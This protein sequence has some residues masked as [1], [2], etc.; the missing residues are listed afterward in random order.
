MP[1]LWGRSSDGR[2]FGSHSKGQGFDSP[3]LHQVIYH[4][5]IKIILSIDGFC[6]ARK[7]FVYGAFGLFC[8]PLQVLCRPFSEG[9]WIA[10]AFVGGL[11]LTILRQIVK[12]EPKIGVSFN[13]SR[14]G[15]ALNFAVK[16]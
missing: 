4:L 9:R 5:L 11:L 10:P 8:F 7:C 3:R 15:C 12:I 2:A 1:H 6:F 13:D 14:K 16:R